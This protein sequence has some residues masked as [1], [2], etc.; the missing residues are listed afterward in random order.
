MARLRLDAPQE[1]DARG[2]ASAAACSAGTGNWRSFDLP[3]DRVR[4]AAARWAA[5][6]DGVERPWLCWNLNDAWCTVQQRLVRAV[7]W[8]P[9]VGWDPACRTGPP[10]L[11][12]GA[13]AIDF[14]ATLGL[15]TL[16]LHF[17]IEFVFLWAPRLAFWHA[18]L[19]VRL[20][21]LEAVARMFESL[22]DHET[23]AVACYGGLMNLFRFRTH[24]YWELLGCTTRGASA[25]QF[26]LGCGWWRHFEL[27]PN[28]PDE[29]E[30]KRRSRHYYDSGVGIM[31]WK[32]RYGGKVREIEESWIDEGHCTAINNPGYRRA[33]NK[34]VELDVNFNLAAMAEKLGI[35][36][37]ITRKREA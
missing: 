29:R 28:C 3:L 4:A 21:K 23:A 13:I 31:Y 10:P 32:R 11:V 36:Q 33:G 7:G 17:P 12:D 27:H 1:V 35:A 6:I 19:L 20:P 25:E 26:R 22:R 18:D 16:W 8:T 2:S 9:V 5:A 15:P 24:R 14:N 37:F 34:G 30:R